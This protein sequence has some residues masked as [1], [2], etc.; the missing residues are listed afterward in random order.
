VIRDIPML[1]PDDPHFAIEHTYSVRSPQFERAVGH[2]LGS[3]VARGNRV[4][5]LLNGDEI[6]PAMLKEIRR[7]R[8][9]ITFESFVYWDGEVADRF[10]DALAERARAGVATH[11]VIDW[12]GSLRLT[13]DHVE[14]MKE[15]GVQLQLYHELPWYDPVRWRALA[16]VEDRTH[17]KILVVDGK[18]G[19][20]GG[21]G[22]ADLWMG[23]A[24]SPEHWRDTHFRVTGPVVAQLQSIFVINWLETGG[25]LLHGD[26]Y[27]PALASAGRVRAHVF[28][29]S[30]QEATENI[31]LMYRL[32]IAS[33]RRSIKLSSA[34]FVPNPGTIKSLQQAAQRGVKIQIIVPG[35]HLDSQ[36]VKAA[37]PALWGD[38]LRA[39]VEI[40]RYQ[41]T[42]YHCKVLIV[43]DAFTSVGS[44][45]FD[46][47]SFQMDDELNLNVFDESF[48]AHQARIFTAD[49]AASKRYTY[50]DW[51]QRPWA[52]KAVNWIARPF[53]REL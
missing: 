29:G 23:N 22:I 17:R 15:A 34:Y 42:M 26:A 5:T 11:V 44:T 30:P 51:L 21:V 24:D 43:D 52:Q 33:A 36:L 46:N 41:P 27:F 4:E 13:S 53:R 14:R 39:G 1:R 38:L 6:F 40:H 48:A 9:S 35:E 3:G 49:L 18:V 8:R 45:N 16:N 7:A 50:E 10:T 28:A 25:Q 20:T 37:S 12:F 47:R 19:F 2:L 31:E 32:A